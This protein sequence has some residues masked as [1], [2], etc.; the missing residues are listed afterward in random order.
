MTA[1][2][3]DYDYDYENENENENEQAYEHEQEFTMSHF[4]DRLLEQV[5]VKGSP[6]CVGID[7]VYDR[8]PETV[9]DIDDEVLEAKLDA[10]FA[11]V[12]KVI[13]AVAEHVPAVKFQAACFERYGPDGLG[14]YHSLVQEAREAGLIVIGDVKRG[15][16]GSTAEHYAAA[17]LL[18]PGA[19]DGDWASPDAVTVNSY[20]GRDGLTPFT[21]LAAKL[22]KG[23]FTLVRTS[24]P[25]GDAI[26]SLQLADGRSV[27]EAVAGLVAEIGS[28][29][30]YL[31]SSGYSLLG[32]VV[33]ATK[34]GDAARLRQ[35]MPQQL[36]LVPG[37]G[38]QGGS[39]DDVRA[40]FKADR[41][42]ALITAS[43]SI[44]YAFEQNPEADW[45]G[46]VEQAAIEMKQQI[47][48]ILA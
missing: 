19:D 23:V 32:A 7:P 2:G 31:G 35:I 24:N 37:F 14:V 10:I 17:T 18:D 47:N 42:G 6:V 28:D 38:A 16:I 21:D 46:A 36:F 41:T 11:F 12:Q 39:A 20:F 25:G 40:C 29:A 33:G 34:P 1:R 13:Q 4:V 22:G 3:R 26:Q 30:N 27:A 43:R 48:A 15:D 44:T 8:L 9:R 5:R 45:P